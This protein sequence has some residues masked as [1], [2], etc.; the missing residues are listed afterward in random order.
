MLAP[1]ILC[2][3]VLAVVPAIAQQGAPAARPA[4]DFP[5]KIGVAELQSVEDFEAK[6]PGLGQVGQYVF[7]GWRMGMYV[8]DKQRKGIAN[9]PDAAQIKTEL[10]QS[11]GDIFEAKKLGHY[12][13]VDEGVQF[14]I[15][16]T[17]APPV[18]HCR[19]FRIQFAAKA[20]EALRPPYD[21]YMCVTTSRQ[22][23]VKLRLSST[24]PSGDQATVFTPVAAAIELVGRMLQ[25]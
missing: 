24:T 10:D 17:G 18:F 22:R 5:K 23:Y 16:P 1:L 6:S 3:V 9:G 11:V 14:A 21:S 8:Y 12:A 15:P 13:A 2:A 19:G 4:F 20:G 25:R 7:Q